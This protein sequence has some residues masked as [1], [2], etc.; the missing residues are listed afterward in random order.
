M[1][2]YPKNPFYFDGVDDSLVT[3]DLAHHKVHE[4]EYF[5]CSDSAT[6]N[7]GAANRKVWRF[8]TPDSAV[9]AHFMVVFYSDLAG[10]LTFAENPTLNAA[11]SAL[12]RLN[13]DRNSGG[14][15]AV[16]AFKDTTLTAEGTI[17]N[18]VIIGTDNPKTQIGGNARF[19]S[20]FILKQNEDYTLVFVASNNATTISMVAEW[21]EA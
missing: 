3:I 12:A 14:V 16:T 15:A 1:P 18:T 19:S 13:N 10:V 2:V 21:Y 17:L 6:I 5:T 20:E 9:R 8:T 7:A 4:G 11:G